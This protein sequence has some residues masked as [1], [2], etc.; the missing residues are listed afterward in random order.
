MPSYTLSPAAQV[1]VERIWYYTVEHWSKQQ[2]ERYTR[3]IQAVCEAL[4]DGSRVGQ[5]ADDIRTGYRKAAVGSHVIFYCMHG[6]TVEV[7]RILHQRMDIERHMQP[8]GQ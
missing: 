3:S 7:I 6:N 4:C 8:S 2:A 5:S 1:D